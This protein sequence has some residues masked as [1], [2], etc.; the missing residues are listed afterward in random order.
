M[1]TTDPHSLRSIAATM[2][3]FQSRR[4]IGILERMDNGVGLYLCLSSWPGLQKV[5]RLRYGGIKP[6]SVMTLFSLAEI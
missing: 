5:A 2:L 3:P 1:S 4:L 6:G